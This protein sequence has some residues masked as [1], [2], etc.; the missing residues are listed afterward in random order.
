VPGRGGAAAL[1]RAGFD[2][3]NLA[4]NHALD[5][6]AVCLDHTR[7]C[8]TAAGISAGGVGYAQAE[9]RDLHVVEKG[10]LSVGFLCY[11]EDGNWTLGAENPGLAYYELDAV[12]DD[13]TRHR[14]T[15]DI[16][17]VSIHADVEFLPVPSPKRIDHS[18][19]IA[20]A[21]ADILL[22]HHPHVPQGIER[23][24]GSLVAYS[25]GNFV[26]AAHSSLNQKL[27]G[28]QTGYSFLL[29]VEVSES[30]VR[31]FERVPIVI[32]KPPD[33][34]PAP[35]EGRKREELEALFSDLDEKLT[36]DDYVRA[37]WRRTAVRLFARHLADNADRP[38]EDV[39][40]E[41]VGR[42]CLVAENRRWME[43]ILAM[44]R[45]SWADHRD[46]PHLYRRPNFRFQRR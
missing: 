22:E 23:V 15:V 18:R 38:V 27:H 36:D 29:L 45:E 33:E 37:T 4:N 41:T 32:G 20:A 10:G 26:T 42:L 7:E 31:G 5:G 40:E 21:G 3:L 6:G 34:R 43:E 46:T 24:D 8:L 12:L 25:L 9:A 13:V 39:I 30:G 16:L 28:P 1:K 35:A 14:P 17:V 44:A 19:R 11:G 2:F